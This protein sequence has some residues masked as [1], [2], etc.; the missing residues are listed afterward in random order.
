MYYLFLDESGDHNLIKIDKSYPVF[1]LAGCIIKSSY[2]NSTFIKK[3]QN[4]KATLF[5]T[6]KI[7]LHTA[8]ITR[9]K[10]GFEKLKNP[11]IRKK[12]YNETNN[13]IKDLDFSLIACI[14]DKKKHYEK[15]RELALDSY[16]LS[17]K[18]VLERFFYFLKENSDTAKIYAESRGSFLDSKLELAYFDIKYSGITYPTRKIRGAEV[19]E[20]FL[21]F[22]FYSKE[23]N[24]S[25]LQIADLCAT[26]IGRNY[27]G[28]KVKEDY[29]IIETKFRRRNNEIHGYGLIIVPEECYPK[30]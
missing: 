1:V 22:K 6:K 7:I 27:V 21:D 4:Y 14:I 18:C 20:K 15:Y 2:Y 8:D 29:K 19:R 26:P 3:V 28:K 30:K 9:N 25:G 24:I 11:I 17:L 16:E 10:N 13:L 12:F 5:G 23:K